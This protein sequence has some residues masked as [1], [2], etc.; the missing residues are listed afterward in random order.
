MNP[1]CIHGNGVTNSELLLNYPRG[2]LGSRGLSRLFF[3]HS[4]PSEPAHSAIAPRETWHDRADKDVV[5]I[6]NPREYPICKQTRSLVRLVTE[7]L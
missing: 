5:E 1:R 6:H 7:G 2:R 4:F 3:T